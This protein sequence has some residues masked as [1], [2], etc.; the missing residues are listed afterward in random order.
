[1]MKD[2]DLQPRDLD[3]WTKRP[4]WLT[5][6]SM[7]S[8]SNGASIVEMVVFALRVETNHTPQL[9]LRERHF[10]QLFFFSYFI[11]LLRVL[12]KLKYCE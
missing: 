9:R 4:L 1:M 8:N 3:Q 6:P 2:A 7:V 10:V 5:V 11:F 12:T